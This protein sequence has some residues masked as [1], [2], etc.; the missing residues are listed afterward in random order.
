L[1]ASP[2][3]GI[4]I[5]NHPEL[6]FYC[7]HFV[8]VPSGIAMLIYWAL[9]MDFTLLSMRISAFVLVP[10]HWAKNPWGHRIGLQ[11]VAGIL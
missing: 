4:I 3:T 7:H 5:P 11:S 9:L 6:F 10:W 1:E 2:K 8:A